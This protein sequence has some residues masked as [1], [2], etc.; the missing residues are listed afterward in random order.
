M[1]L[2]ALWRRKLLVALALVASVAIGVVSAYRVQLSPF[3]LQNRGVEYAIGSASLLVDAGQSTLVDATVSVQPLTQ[4]AQIIT[5]SLAGPEVRRL[6]ATAARIDPAKL[7]VTSLGAGGASDPGSDR[8]AVEIVARARPYRVT[9]RPSQTSPV[10]IVT[11]EAPTAPEA[12]RLAASAVRVAIDY[13]EDR[14]LASRSRQNRVVLRSVDDPVAGV[15]N[16]NGATQAAA[17]IGG[18]AFVALLFLVLLVARLRDDRAP[19]RATGDAGG[20]GPED[21]ALPADL[22]G[23]D[24]RTGESV[25]A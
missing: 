9:F 3:E 25:R 1:S 24:E 22:A 10:I 2:G 23:R 17:V 6:T 14:L 12:Q 11:T 19:V 21:D 8:R 13:V 7:A 15:V 18:G 5:A 20:E 4:R 16:P